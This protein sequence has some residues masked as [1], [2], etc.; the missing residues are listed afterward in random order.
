LQ[1]AGQLEHFVHSVRNVA[2]ITSREVVPGREEPSF[3]FVLRPSKAV[4]FKPTLEVLAELQLDS[5]EQPD[6]HFESDVQ[7]IAGEFAL[8]L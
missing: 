4:G 1:S 5:V 3:E 6:P 8:L 7:E 2:I